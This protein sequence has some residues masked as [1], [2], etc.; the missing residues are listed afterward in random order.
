VHFA[1]SAK[2][3]RSDGFVFAQSYRH[4]YR[5]ILASTPFETFFEPYWRFNRK[6]AKEAWRSMSRILK[7]REIQS[8]IRRSDIESLR[9]EL[10]ELLSRYAFIDQPARFSKGG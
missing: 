7:G 8:G 3:W 4:R 1:G 10:I 2:P 5:D 6:Q 9:V